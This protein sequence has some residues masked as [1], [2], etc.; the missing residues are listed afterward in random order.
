MNEGSAAPRPPSD[1][2]TFWPSLWVTIVGTVL[3]GGILALGVAWVSAQ[4]QRGIDEEAA[5][6]ATCNN[7]QQL[8]LLEDVMSESDSELEYQDN[9]GV[10]RHYPASN[11]VDGD[12]QTAWIA[13]TEGQ[14]VGALLTLTLPSAAD[15]R[16]ICVMNGYA[17]NTEVFTAN[18]N[19]RVLEVTTANGVRDAALPR[20]SEDNVFDYQQLVFAPGRTSTIQL[21]IQVADVPRESDAY[22]PASASLS[23]I[24]VWIR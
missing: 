13:E 18:G 7:P 19:V 23:E 11:A 6:V 5:S 22:G 9:T 15:V 21:R 4:I 14:G 3:L 24:E 10:V 1:W 8:R 17:S 16:L 2:T 20:L 12:R